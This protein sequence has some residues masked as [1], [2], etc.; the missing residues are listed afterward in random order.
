MERECIGAMKI[1]VLDGYAA[2][3]GD[4]NWDG[5]KRL[6][7][8]TVY[9][10]Y[11]RYDEDE[12]VRRAAGAEAVILTRTRLTANAFGRLPDLKY[13]GLL[14]TGYN[15]IDAA[16]CRAHGVVVCNVPDYS[17]PSVAQHVFA[18]LL[19][20]TNRVS[21]LDDEAH[22][23]AWTGRPSFNQLA[24]PIE[25]IA[26]K[27]MGIVGY[28]TIGK[29]VGAIARAFGME[30]VATSHTRTSGM[31]EGARMAPLGE[32]L[33]QAD[34]LSLNCPLTDETRGLI[35]KANLAR[36][37]REAIL[38]NTARGPVVVEEDLAA[39]LNAGRIRAAA[40]D[41]LAKEPQV[42]D[43]PLVHAKNCIITPHVAWA[44]FEARRRMLRIVEDS[45]RAY[46]EGHPI[47]RVI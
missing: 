45:L 13:I 1:A 7:E 4:L 37:K 6:G 15:M 34:V 35:N 39:A 8:T 16:A 36:M 31:Y 28:G 29:R 41:V 5:V 33:A 27:T 46:I 12:V 17:T 25:E 20:V 30:V 18:L 9:E 42:E 19:A 26:G 40:V 14:S 11:D 24:Y 23:G 2:N 22:R 21:A 44:T 3:P 38:I 10:Y 47:H 43:S 32:V